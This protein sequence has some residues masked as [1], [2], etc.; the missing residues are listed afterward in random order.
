[1]KIFR[2]YQVHDKQG[3]VEMEISCLDG[4]HC[5]VHFPHYECSPLRRNGGMF[6]EFGIGQLEMFLFA[7]NPEEMEKFLK[8]LH[9]R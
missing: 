7:Y 2:N 3:Y 6:T 1:M 8:Y 5:N 4:M 9:E